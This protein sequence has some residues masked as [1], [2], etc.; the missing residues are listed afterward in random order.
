MEAAEIQQI[1]T[2]MKKI[3]IAMLIASHTDKIGY[4][5]IEDLLRK[6][7][8]DNGLTIE[9]IRVVRAKDDKTGKD[10]QNEKGE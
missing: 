3:Q 5:N 7:L 1:G 4:W 6:V 9:D 8:N 10:G 2:N